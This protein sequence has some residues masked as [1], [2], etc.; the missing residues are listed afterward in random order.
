MINWLSTINLQMI[1]LILGII[2]QWRVVSNCIVY[3]VCK[4]SNRA[5][6]QDKKENW[7]PAFVTVN[8]GR[9]WW[10]FFCVCKGGVFTHRF[11]NHKP[12][13]QTGLLDYCGPAP[14][15]HEYK[16]YIIEFI[17]SFYYLLSIWWHFA[18]VISLFM[19][20]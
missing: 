9:F 12:R 20:M 2:I 16:G 6:I 8:F 5:C 10:W 17:R 1:W 15:R 7:I 3:F 19:I 18:R 11:D 14:K 13:G 4:I